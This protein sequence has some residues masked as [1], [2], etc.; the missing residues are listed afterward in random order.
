MT[1][2]QMKCFLSLVQT[3]KMSETAT[4]MG[5]SL[6]TL[7]KYIDKIEDELSARLFSKQEKRLMLTRAGELAFPSIEYMVKQYEEQCVEVVKHSALRQM[8]VNVVMAHHQMKIM[9]RLITFAQAETGIK[10]TITEAPVSEICTMLD[11]GTAD[12]GIIYEQLVD[13][14]YPIVQPMRRDRLVAVVSKQHHLAG[15]DTISV[16]ELKDDIFYLFKGDHLM[17]RYQLRACI[18][19]GFVPTEEHSDLRVS[20]ILKYVESGCGVSLL[21]ENTVNTL[22]TNGDVAVLGLEGNPQL[23]MCALSASAYP[24]EALSKLLAFL[25]GENIT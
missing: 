2:L 14:K 5:L 25:K 12:I 23:T 7:S 1:F 9:R 4:A 24:T 21:V 17:Y 18:S 10:L 20:A 11:S 15:R 13:R 3:R 8:T 19:A 16:D 6:S 22:D